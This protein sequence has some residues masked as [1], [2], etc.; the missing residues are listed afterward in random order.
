M[1]KRFSLLLAVVLVVAMLLPLI[2]VISIP[3]AA[4]DDD[5]VMEVYVVEGDTKTLVK[6]IKRNEVDSALPESGSNVINT[7]TG[8][9]KDV[10]VEVLSDFTMT[11]GQ[12]A[13]YAASANAT[14]TVNGNGYHIT[15]NRNDGVRTLLF[16][17]N[18]GKVVINDLKITNNKS[19]GI[20]QI[21]GG[22]TVDLVDCDFRSLAHKGFWLT[23]VANLN[24]LGNTTI[25]AAQEPIYFSGGNS[26]GDNVF[27]DT[28]ATLIGMNGNA[29]GIDATSDHSV[30]VKGTLYAKANAINCKLA[31][32]K[33]V[34]DGATVYGNINATAGTVEF[35]S[36][37][38]SGTATGA[39]VDPSVET[40]YVAEVYEGSTLVKS[41]YTAE[42]GPY[43]TDY[44][45]TKDTTVKLYGDVFVGHSQM[46]FKP[47]AGV[48]LTIDG[49]PNNTGVNAKIIGTETGNPAIRTH[50]PGKVIFDRVDYT[51]VN[52]T[53]VQ[54]YSGSQLEI[55]DSH[56]VSETGHM[57]A[58][59]SANNSVIT[60][61]GNSVLEAGGAGNIVYTGWISQPATIN[62]QDGATVISKNPIVMAHANAANVTFN[63]TNA[64]VVGS[65]ADTTAKVN[66]TNSFVTG[67]TAN[68]TVSNVVAAPAVVVNGTNYDTFDAAVT[69]ANAATSDVVIS[70]FKDVTTAKNENF[71]SAT[72]NI[73]I[74]GYND[75]LLTFTGG[76]NN[77]RYRA[78]GKTLTINNLNIEANAS[79]GCFIQ[80]GHAGKSN[81]F[82]LN[83]VNLAANVKWYVF[84][85]MSNDGKASYFT[86]INCT[87]SDRM[88]NSGNGYL[89]STGNAGDHK[90]HS[91]ITFVDSYVAG[92]GAVQ[93]NNGSTAEIN[94]INSVVASNSKDC[95]TL[96]TPTGLH[97]SAVS[98]KTTLNIDANSIVAAVAGKKV[99][100]GTES[101]TVV[102]NN[103]AATKVVAKIGDTEYTT[104]DAAITAAQAATGDVTIELLADGVITGNRA[105][106]TT[107]D[108]TIDGNNYK[109]Y[110][111]APN[112]SLIWNV[113]GKTLTIKNAEVYASSYNGCI[114][115]MSQNNC[116]A[117]ALVLENVDMEAYTNWHLI[118]VMS[119]NND[120]PSVTFKNVN[121]D[122][123]LSGDAGTGSI[124]STGNN[125][126]HPHKL[127]FTVENSTLKSDTII[128]SNEKSSINAVIK[129]S[130]LVAY[131]KDAITVSG[132]VAGSSINVDMD[133]TI[134]VPAGKKEVNATAPETTVF[135]PYDVIFEIYND[136][137]DELMYTVLRKDVIA[138]LTEQNISANYTKLNAD[139]NVRIEMRNDYTVVGNYSVEFYAGAGKTLT[140][141]GNGYKLISERSGGQRTTTYEGGGTVLLNGMYIQNTAGSS[142]GQYYGNTTVEA[143]DCTLISDKHMGFYLT[144]QGTLKLTGNTTLKTASNAINVV[145]TLVNTVEIGENV[146]L[147]SD[148][149][150]LNLGNIGAI[151]ITS[152]G[153]IKAG[154]GK[155]AVNLSNANITLNITGTVNG[156]IN[157]TAG[158]VNI[159]AAANFARSEV[160][161]AGV[162]NGDIAVAG[163]T[164][165]VIGGTVNGNTKVDNGTVSI[166]E[167]TITGNV[168][169]T[170]GDVTVS[171]G[172]VAGDV[173]VSGGAIEVKEEAALTGNLTVS[174]GNVSLENATLA[175][176]VTAT[177][178]KVTV[179][180]S[181]ISGDVSADKGTFE[182]E[183]GVISG[184]NGAYEVVDGI[185]FDG[186]AIRLRND[187][188]NGLRFVNVISKVLIDKINAAKDADTAVEYGTIIFPKKYIDEAGLTVV[189]HAALIDAGYTAD[190]IVDI[191][192]SNGLTMD[193]IGNISLSAAIIEIKGSHYD[194]EFV[195]VAYAKYVKGGQTVYAYSNVNADELAANAKSVKSISEAALAD[196]QKEA[197][198]EYRFPYNGAYTK[199][200]PSKI[201]VL[202]GFAGL[203]EMPEA[204][205]APVNPDR[206][207]VHSHKYTEVVTA[208]TCFEPGYTTYTCSCGHS[209]TGAET[210][211]AHDAITHVAALAATCDENGNIEYWFCETCGSAWL[212][213]ACML[214]T[215]LRAVV[216]TATGHADD[217]GDY[218]CDGCSTKMLPEA[219]TTLTIPQ[220][221]AIAK[222]H[223]HNT[224]TTQ[225]YY[226]TGIVTNVY[227]TQFGN[228]YLKDD[229]G[230]EICMYGLYSADGKTRYDSMT[231]KPV[232][233]DE[234]TVYTVLGM[235]NTTAQGKNAWMDDVVA[236]EHNYVDVVKEATC[237]N[238]G[239]TTHT[240]SICKD[241]YKDTEVEALGH[242]TEKG[243]CD[244]CGQEIGGDAPVVK[245]SVTFEFGANGSAVHADGNDLGT[246]KT[247]TEGDAELVLTDMSKV[248]GPAYDAKGNSCIKLGTS[249]VVGKISF[250]V[251]DDVTEVVIRVAKYKSNTTKV[252]VNGT[253]YTIQG[254]SNDG[255]YDEIV[256]DTTTTKT[257]TLVTVTGGVRA[258]INSI[259]YNYD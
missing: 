69:A 125:N 89:Y 252:D 8:A 180:D 157:M 135:T 200:S 231:Y 210:D 48:T 74:N 146:T 83:N 247:Y 161:K 103:N 136:D 113:A 75:A 4:A 186:A 57:F 246:S 33:V 121:I 29:I 233:G 65:F 147:E 40:F 53:A 131:T 259:T 104:L 76:G 26:K 202:E 137:T 203:R 102:V 106:T 66:V 248:Y 116:A 120:T 205:S 175:G 84:N 245:D 195:S 190:K 178:G 207:E 59:S 13:L 118:N 34:L 138:K 58:P 169:V 110:L 12:L 49:D 160:A 216:L 11:S 129:N 194:W 24:V 72:Q 111:S 77:I 172:T 31:S 71:S 30:T 235:Y 257:I 206:P 183:S 107:G 82:V 17:G 181:S 21:Y 98:T 90:H 16:Q 214:N 208:P 144:S 23:N 153:T 191:A 127:N 241:S 20:A 242:T 78:D 236:H 185:V 204:P 1:K 222:L 52:S 211:P 218:K 142:V 128:I 122:V 162:V 45:V 251:A 100:N 112:N 51:K 141:N 35:K 132:S 60:V 255:A 54:F 28:G 115:Q 240:C 27:V 67:S 197:G 163:G 177:G 117:N 179:S 152:N 143:K 201:A 250:T 93:V 38:L 6:S 91:V 219:G 87:F 95:F 22:L 155:N 68:A 228:M 133:S 173:T 47:A 237:T 101:A 63:V 221:L 156:K 41:L 227:N 42:V 171:G 224:Y 198:G 256:I 234:L 148:T 18:K 159:G 39:T 226:I 126:D 44:K 15:S 170:G 239:Y 254:A 94:V 193:E 217:N 158:T 43:F 70:I 80:Q 232:E 109:I 85:N 46:Q 114:C 92:L 167:G 139:K 230:N 2:P 134:T 5:I 130:D 168:E 165:N 151:T 36:G 189:T 79:N 209:Y 174:A 3:A 244:R 249:K 14:T 223:A 149:N 64:G 238:G 192:A 154:A 55:V 105:F 213:E 37:K 140:V 7:N 25:W 176:D 196:T 225:K 164:L 150:T 9:G 145:T 88:S 97:A 32:A 182:V 61:K 184:T 119:K 108:L 81:N 253:A 56:W 19:A 188:T 212:D 10:I 166:A 229:A 99:V 243:I 96:G 258:M 123:V 215:N 187:Y 220:A 73:T 62:I 50:G 86:A 124:V 199:Y